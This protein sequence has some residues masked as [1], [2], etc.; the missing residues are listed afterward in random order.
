MRHSVWDF[1]R[2]GWKGRRPL[3]QVFWFP[4]LLD[5]LIFI[6]LQW[7]LGAENPVFWSLSIPWSLYILIWWP[8]AVWRCAN[9]TN[10]TVLT[11][12]AKAVVLVSMGA[13]VLGFGVALTQ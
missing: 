13:L 1:I 8:V 4:A 5:C 12:G 11:Y 3:Y 9:N 10:Y 7:I 2:D 6:P